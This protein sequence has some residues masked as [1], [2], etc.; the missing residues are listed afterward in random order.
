VGFGE[1]GEREEHRGRPMDSKGGRAECIG[2]RRLGY[3]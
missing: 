1:A 3:E 2:L